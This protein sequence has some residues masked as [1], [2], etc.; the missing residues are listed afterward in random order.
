MSFIH[1]EAWEA[2]F[3]K[4]CDRLLSEG[5]PQE[6][7]TIELGG[8]QS[9][10]VRFNGAKVRQTGMVTDGN[11]KLELICG[12]KTATATFPFSRDLETDTR[13]GLD[14]LA[15]LRQELPQ[16]PDD[17]YIVEPE[18]LG[19]THDAYG[20]NLLDPEQVVHEIL[21][22]VQGL[23]FTGIYTSGPVVRANRNSEGQRHWFSTESY[24]LD[25]SVIAPC[26]KA[27]KATL[28]GANWNTADFEK[29]IHQAK[30]QL[31]ILE[32]PV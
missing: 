8:E 24:C 29:Q 3:D 26:E 10:F 32:R 13:T 6:H 17:P 15:A 1:I 22:T 5:Q 19:S 20:G 14:E 2:A 30:T 7:L 25:Y 23:D 9:Q 21:P 11:I 18:H 4:L 28:A 16:L 31:A 27:V 12:Q